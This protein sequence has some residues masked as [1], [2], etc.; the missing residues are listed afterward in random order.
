[1][2][3]YIFLFSQGL[4]LMRNFH[5]A[6][7]F[8]VKEFGGVNKFADACRVSS[9]DIR[10]WQRGLHIPNA[11]TLDIIQH[12]LS[13]R[14]E[15]APILDLISPDMINSFPDVMNILIYKHGSAKNLA[16]TCAVSESAVC[17][18]RSGMSTPGTKV[19]N[20]FED[21]LSTAGYHVRILKL[22]HPNS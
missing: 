5:E 12:H 8:L 14:G 13:L 6:I 7:D 17:K 1:M 11:K 10:L 4:N 3:S 20:L 2:L 9:S 19:L 18:W 22:L 15:E 21:L 16:D